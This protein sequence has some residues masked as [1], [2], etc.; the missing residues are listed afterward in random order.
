MG[1]FDALTPEELAKRWRGAVNA[2]TLA[3]WRSRKK[4]PPYI[5][6]G[7]D[8][9]YPVADLEAWEQANIVRPQQKPGSKAGKTG[10]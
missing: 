5:K 9:F 10:E 2:T 7:A 3:N 6:I 1:D 4:G 8:I